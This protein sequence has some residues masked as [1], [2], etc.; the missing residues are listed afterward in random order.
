[1]KRSSII[2]SL[3]ALAVCALLPV[4]LGSLKNPVP[5]P[6]KMKAHSQM[7]L[8]L[9]DGSYHATAWGEATHCGE[10]V[11]LGSG[12]FNPATGE[13]SGGGTIIAANGDEI[14][15]DSLTMAQNIITGGTGR[16]EGATGEFIMVSMEQTG[17]DLDPVA[18]T[19]TLSF[20]WTASGTITY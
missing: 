15:F 16:F 17:M 7:V 2:R 1:M 11:S 13:G 8:S 14:F 12:V 10:F 18:G 4:M 5:R 6:I 3:V 19:M 20:V 9:A